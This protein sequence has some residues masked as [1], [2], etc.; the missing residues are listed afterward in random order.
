[1]KIK[2]GY[3]LKQVAGSYMIVPLGDNFVDFT[4]VI[5]TNET[6]A[7]LWEALNTEKTK[8]EL[9]DAVM[10]E[11]EGADRANVEQDIDKFIEALKKHNMLEPNS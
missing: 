3:S 2:D 11:F 7:F 5:T 4:S 1:M 9:C 10:N 6:G 8:E